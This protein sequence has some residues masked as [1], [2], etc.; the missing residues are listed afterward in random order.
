[1]AAE[2]GKPLAMTDRTRGLIQIHLAR[3]VTVEEIRFVAGRFQVRGFSVARGAT[4]RRVDGVVTHKTV[5]HLREGG[6]RDTIRYFQSAMTARA[7]VLRPVQ[8]GSQIARCRQVLFGIDC[9][10]DLP[11][12]GVAHLDVKRMV[13][14]RKVVASRCLDLRRS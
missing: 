7:R 6:W 5:G 14:L 8:L 11:S 4:E 10:N 12:D 9:T 13:E 1:M 2:A 3:G